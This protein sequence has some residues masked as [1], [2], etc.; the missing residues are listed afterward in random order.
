MTIPDHLDWKL[1]EE[2]LGSGG[3]GTVHLVYH[4]DDP[5]RTPRALK[6]LNNGVS[7]QAI[8]RFH[9][10]I[11]TVSE[12]H[13]YA[14]IEVLDYSPPDAEFQ[15]LVMLFH[16][17]AKTI[18]EV[19]LTPNPSLNPFH[20]N[21]LKCLYVFEQL[22]SAIHACETQHSPIFHRDISPKNILV[23]PDETI[24][25]ID[26]GL[27]HTVGDTTITLTGES[28]GTRYYAPP[29]CGADS[30][31][32]IGT[33][34]DIY[35]AAK[36]LWSTITSRRVFDREDAILKRRS[37]QEMFPQ[38]EETWHLD[39]IFKNIIRY[40]PNKRIKETES[41]LHLVHEIVHDVHKGIPPLEAIADRCPSCK[42]ENIEIS[43][44][45]HQTFGGYMDKDITVHECAACG[46][47]FARRHETLNENIQNQYPKLPPPTLN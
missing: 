14:V 2:N 16:K 17:G 18:E 28:L 45:R 10:E 32:E 7:Q 27:C 6:I 41:V 24:R 38:K 19:C 1:I 40:N 25:L 43:R 23:L 11:K 5:K 21:T 9:K 39:K 15:Y 30:E 37:M 34:T 26:F 44:L 12:I 35:S 36:V 8:R 20:G 29:E 33:Y 46:F 47:I 4:K 13:H 42:R 22:I 31:Y 3:Q